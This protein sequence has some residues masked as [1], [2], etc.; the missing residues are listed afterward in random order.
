MQTATGLSREPLGVRA[1]PA[2]VVDATRVAEAEVSPSAWTVPLCR[3]PDALTVLGDAASATGDLHPVVGV[4]PTYPRH[5]IALVQ[6]AA[7]V[8][9]VPG[10]RLTFGVGLSHQS[11]IEGVHATLTQVRQ[12][13]P[14]S[15]CRS[16]LRSCARGGAVP[17][18][19]L[20][21]RRRD[22]RTRHA[23]RGLARRRAVGA[24]GDGG[25]S[26]RR[27][28]RHLARGLGDPG[29]RDRP[30]ADG[31]RRGTRAGATCSRSTAN[32]TRPR[33]PGNCCTAGETVNHPRR[34][35][36]A[37]TGPEAPR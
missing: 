35:R 1:T 7:M 13:T 30:D 26:P 33:G 36:T 28:S 5:P 25:R 12:R 9:A 31:S 19:L 21:A 3:G 17:G 20:R 6:Q 29:E 34:A 16:S 15:T 4:V 37:P 32:R 23:P 8:Q 14:G 27:R 11:L 2:E 24:H 22:H 18:T 10:D